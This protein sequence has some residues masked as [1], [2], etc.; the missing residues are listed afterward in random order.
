MQSSDA[1][2]TGR[3]VR[4]GDIAP[5]A[6]SS[7]QKEADVDDQQSPDTMPWSYSDRMNGVGVNKTHQ[8]MRAGGG[9]P[10]SALGTALEVPAAERRPRVGRLPAQLPPPAPGAD[11]ALPDPR[12][13]GDADAEPAAGEAR[14]ELHEYGY[15]KNYVKLLHV[16]R[17]GATHSIRE[18][19]V[20]THLR[21]NSKRDYL[22]GDNRHIIATDTQK[23]TVYVL[24]KKHGVE[25]PEDFGLLVCSH[26]LYTYRHVEEVSV[27]VEEYPWERLQSDERPH[28][29][30]FIFSPT[31][32]RFCTVTQARNERPKI[33][34]GLRDLRVLKTTQSAFKDFI[35]DEYRTLPDANDRIFSTI[36]SATW[37]YSTANGVN[38]DKVWDAVK[39]CILDKFAGPPDTGIFSP[40]VQNTLYLTEKMVLDKVQQIS[41]IEMWMPNKHYFTIDLS[42][43]PRSI[44]GSDNKEVYEPVDKPSGIIHAKLARKDLKAKL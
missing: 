30:A 12:P 11:P 22:A 34:G 43:F 32:Y 10:V 9:L 15:G 31:A 18:Y 26:F 8:H 38:F 36:V 14:Y 44:V 37:D 23:N 25:S 21:L 29:H 16:K 17:D 20:N 42:K 19:E 2:K 6:A 1:F 27:H 39:E 40:S 4:P 28:N 5:P 24:A 41:Q 35:Q 33:K 3:P 13:A 7:D